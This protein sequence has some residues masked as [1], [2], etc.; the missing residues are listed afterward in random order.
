MVG[1]QARNLAR[2]PIWIVMMLIQ[3]MI[4][5]VLYSQLFRRIV[6][7]PGFDTDSYIDFLAPAVVIMTAFFGGTWSGMGMITDLDRGVVERFLATPARRSA[8]VLSQVMRAAATAAI[9]GVI[10]LVVALA[11]GAQNGGP[12]GWAAI[13][14]AGMLVAAGFSGIS[15]GVALLTRREATMIAV[16]NFIGLPLMFFS[17]MLIDFD[18]IPGWM[19]WAA[20][21]NPVQWA[22]DAARE[23]VLADP[24]WPLVALSLGLLAGFTAAATAFATWAFRSYQRTL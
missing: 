5:L 22:V 17:A 20:R 9:Q 16:A 12:D 1:R 8:I 4:W 19:Q 23:P 7:L 14:V 10:I 2:E 15:Q 6:E 18:L 3:P 11:L 21:F 13:L 24:D